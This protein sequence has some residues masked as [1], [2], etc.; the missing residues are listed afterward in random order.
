MSISA[1]A[2]AIAWSFNVIRHY[3]RQD[4]SFTVKL[5][6]WVSRMTE[7]LPRI[8]LIALVTAEYNVHVVYIIWYRCIIGL[9]YV[10]SDRIYSNTSC[11][12]DLYIADLLLGIIGNI[13][14]F[15]MSDV[16]KCQKKDKCGGKFLVGYYILFYAEN[17]V[18]LY[19][20]FTD[21]PLYVQYKFEGACSNHEWYVPYVFVVV[22]LCSILQPLFLYLYYWLRR[23]QDTQNK[24]NVSERDNDGKFSR[25]CISTVSS[26]YSLKNKDNK[27][28]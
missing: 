9:V 28:I 22:I 6:L 25:V 11:C 8:L 2:L 26:N 3:Y 20:W 4:D 21:D 10:C 7:I 18:M 24:H 16:F 12:D 14:G 15:C 27:S 17:G 13:F 1:S 23:K 5:L 19:M